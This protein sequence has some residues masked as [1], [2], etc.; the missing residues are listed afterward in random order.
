MR[1]SSSCLVWRAARQRQGRRCACQRSRTP[2]T[3]GVTVRDLLT[4]WSMSSFA[5]RK[6]SGSSITAFW[7]AARSRP[8]PVRQL[9]P[10][11]RRRAEF[12]AGISRRANRPSPRG[13]VAAAT[14]RERPSPVWWPQAPPR[15]D[16]RRHGIAL[17]FVVVTVTDPRMVEGFR[18]LAISVFRHHGGVAVPKSV[19]DVSSPIAKARAAA[20]TSD[21]AWAW[22]TSA[23]AVASPV[24][25]E[26]ASVNVP[27]P[28]A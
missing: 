16:F 1:S 13:R 7:Q 3:A 17:G 25:A 22:A 14:P 12:P 20:L 23:R 5:A 18:V 27:T 4:C 9:R 11:R 21:R 28:C 2:T 8:S 26:A 6:M 10:I 24:C 15:S 19:L